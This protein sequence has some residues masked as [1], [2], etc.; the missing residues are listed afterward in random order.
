MLDRSA[1]RLADIRVLHRSAFRFV[2]MRM[3]ASERLQVLR[4]AR[5]CS[6]SPGRAVGGATLRR[7]GAQVSGPA[8]FSAAPLLT[9]RIC[10]S[11]VS[12]ANEASYPAG[13]EAEPRRGVG[14]QGRPPQW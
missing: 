5:C 8:R 13:P 4:A 7:R 10:W 9:C 1:C 3:L 14:L 12:A 2:E 11:V 6:R